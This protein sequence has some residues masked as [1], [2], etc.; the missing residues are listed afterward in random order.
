MTC[1]R[2]SFIVNGVFVALLT[3]TRL[4]AADTQADLKAA[5]ARE[6]IGPK[7]SMDDVRK[8]TAARVPPVPEAK[9]VAEWEQHANRMRKETLDRVVFRGEAA[10]WRDAKTKVEMLDTIAG[11]QGY[12]IHKLRYEA[13]PGMWIPALLY[14]PEKLAGKVPV[15]LNVNGHDAKGK[16]ADYKQVRCINM[17]KRGIIVLNLEWF[18]MGQLREAGFTHARMNQLDLCGTSGLAP[19]YLAMSRGLDI[20]LSLEHADSSR[21]GVSGLSGGGWQTI[22]ISSLDTRVTLTNPVAGYS[23][24][25]TRIDNFSDLGDSEQTPVDLGITA[26]YAQ[27][28]AMLAPRSALLTFNDKDDCCFAS[29]HALPPLVAAAEPIYKLYGKESRLRSHRNSDPGTHNFFLDNRQALYRMIRDQWYDGDDKAFP[30]AE[31]ASDKEVKTADELK[32]EIPPPNED[33][34]TLATKLAESLPRS[35]PRPADSTAA[36]KWRDARVKQLTG[37]VKPQ[38]YDAAAETV[39]TEKLGDTEVIRWRLKLNAEWTIPVV[40]LARAKPTK[41][42]LVIGDE[43]RAALAEKIEALLASGHRVFAVDPFYFGES[44]VES[45]AYLFALLVSTVG[46]RPLGV[47]ASQ[48]IAAAQW[49]KSQGQFD[50]LTLVTVGPRT[51]VIGLTAAA[52]DARTISAVEL[53]Q[54][55]TSLKLVLEQNRTFD[56]SPELF[57]FGLLESFDVPQL[58]ELIA[59]RPVS[60][61]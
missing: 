10:K 15:F 14:E 49:I 54:P 23:S 44:K 43:G 45:R 48:V 25:R 27:L 12:R 55:L 59:P 4:C 16:A 31:I 61:Q 42:A 26:D 36:P 13:L 28:T 40:D 18:G 37:V 50:S 2:C 11:G 1:S 56:Q 46:E 24:F 3:A 39:S 6:I 57:C 53:H 20:L 32:I 35:E 58:K 22:I 9:S 17:A 5:L 51:S 41:A 60:I 8:F 34:H 7:Q 30:G 29:D 47:Q 19:F 52:L 21:V 38:R 33:F